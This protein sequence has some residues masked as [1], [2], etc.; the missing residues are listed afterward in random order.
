MTW[1][2]A[3]DGAQKTEE[4]SSSSFGQAKKA[5]LLVSLQPAKRMQDIWRSD[6]LTRIISIHFYMSNEHEQMYSTWPLW[7]ASKY[8][9]IKC[10]LKQRGREACVLFQARSKCIQIKWNYMHF[11]HNLFL[12]FV[13]RLPKIFH[14]IDLFSMPFLH[15]AGRYVA[16]RMAAVHGRARANVNT[17]LSMQCYNSSALS[18]HN[19]RIFVNAGHMILH[20]IIKRASK[21][22]T[23]MHFEVK[24]I[25]H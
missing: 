11:L 22:S 16:R 20:A 19:R 9:L 21:K 10:Q 7:M 18:E 6:D 1:K 13:P 12:L 4:F 15:F 3:L 8:A 14:Q 5:I 24:S 25:T 17:L 23:C 2:R